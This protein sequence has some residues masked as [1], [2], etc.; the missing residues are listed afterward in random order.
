MSLELTPAKRFELLSIETGWKWIPREGAEILRDTG[1]YAV[2]GEWLW[3]YRDGCYR[4]DGEQLLRAQVADVL[5]NEW[6]RGRADD[7]VTYVRDTSPRLATEPPFDLV[8]VRNGLLDVNT[9]ELIEHDPG[10]LFPVQLPVTYDPDTECPAIHRF[11]AEALEP[12]DQRLLLEVIAYLITPD[13][14]MQ[15]AFML[16]GD[17]GGGKTVTLN[18]IE[19]LLGS[20]N[21]S[22]VSLH[23]L[24]DDRFATADIYGK[25]A[26][27]FA[28]LDAHAPQSSSAFKQITGG[29]TIRGERKH[30]PPF[31]FKPTARLLFSAN[32][33]PP[34]ADSSNAFFDRW[35][36]IPYRRVFRGTS[37]EDTHLIDKLTTA[38]ELSGLLNHALAVLPELRRRRRFP[39]SDSS[40]QAAAEFRVN[41]DS[42]AGFLHER[43]TVALDQRVARAAL[44]ATY[45]DWCADCNRKAFSRQ[46]T[47]ARIREL[48][49]HNVGEITIRGVDYWNGIGL[50]VP[51]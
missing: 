13:N 14:S 1:P 38:S 42:V 5:G 31:N 43:C 47:N 19:A 20:E 7:V 16:T 21:V 44:Y 49:K 26:N 2:G 18:L 8:N 3:A 39:H 28:D 50:G 46:K 4:A 11:L 51:E 10:Y 33:A 9:L 15:R 27:T 32:Q 48:H 12:D 34:T 24:D 36:I 40:D 35:V 22:H 17:G 29:D 41:S 23:K 6:R 25:L 30:R 45:K 37:A